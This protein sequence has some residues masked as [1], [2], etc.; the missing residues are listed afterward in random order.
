MTFDICFDVVNEQCNFVVILIFDSIIF[1]N[2]LNSFEHFFIVLHDVH[3]DHHTIFVKIFLSIDVIVF[4]LFIQFVFFVFHFEFIRIEIVD[5]KNV[6]D[7]KISI[8]F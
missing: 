3:I 5:D 1:V 4:F 6:D 8:Y 2:F 7:Q